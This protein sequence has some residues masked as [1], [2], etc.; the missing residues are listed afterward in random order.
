[1]RVAAREADQPTRAPRL[2]GLLRGWVWALVGFL[3]GEYAAGF[4]LQVL[5][6]AGERELVLSWTW[7][8]WML[9]AL[10]CGAGAG[11]AVPAARDRAWWSWGVAAAPIPVGA[12]FVTWWYLSAFDAGSDGLV[13]AALG[14]VLVAAVVATGIGLLRT[15]SRGL[16]AA[17]AD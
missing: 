2:G 14:Q 1:M 4:A 9:A 8:P 6:R 12:F 5:M 16:D 15:R 7:V 13:L 11:L 10:L 3:V 17:Q